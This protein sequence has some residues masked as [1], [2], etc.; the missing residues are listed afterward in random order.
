VDVVLS[1]VGSQ[2]LWGHNIETPQ[3]GSWINTHMIDITGWVLGRSSPAVT[4]E[5]VHD[6]TVLQSGPIDIRSPDITAVFPEV[7]GA[8]R[9]GFRTAVSVPVM[10]KRELGVQAVLQDQGSVSLGIVQR[11]C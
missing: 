2:Q 9:S 4:L 11:H 7:P 8:E 5:V 10:T 1:E 3:P 6:G